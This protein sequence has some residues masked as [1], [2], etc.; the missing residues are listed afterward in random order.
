MKIRYVLTVFAAA[1][2]ITSACYAGDTTEQDSKDA[3]AV[4]DSA[5]K[6][7]LSTPLSKVKFFGDAT[8]GYETTFGKS[9]C[10][11]AKNY[12]QDGMFSEVRAGAMIQ[13]TKDLSMAM[14]V[15]AGQYPHCFMV[16]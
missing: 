13:L 1:A 11:A 14:Q 4:A 2:A 15:T 6:V 3:K 5:S 7:D 8:V 12:H 10:A 9:N 16:H